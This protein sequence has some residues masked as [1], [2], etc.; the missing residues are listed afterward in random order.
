MCL[1][2]VYYNDFRTYMKHQ[3]F[4]LVI[5]NYSKDNYLF[6]VFWQHFSI[7]LYFINVTKIY[8][9]LHNIIV[10]KFITLSLTNLDFI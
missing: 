2:S 9:I 10:Y 1:C 7:N 6:L 8:L 3:Q 5:I 4:F